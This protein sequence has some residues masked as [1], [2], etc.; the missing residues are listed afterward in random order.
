M[1]EELNEQ[2]RELQQRIVIKATDLLEGNKPKRISWMHYMPNRAWEIT[3]KFEF[4]DIAIN[5]ILGRRLEIRSRSFIVD[6]G[7]LYIEELATVSRS[8]K[9]V[10]ILKITGTSVVESQPGYTDYSSWAE[11]EKWSYNLLTDD[12]DT[13]KGQALLTLLGNIQSGAETGK[14]IF[15]EKLSS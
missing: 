15:D 8:S 4:A 2:N 7:R 10:N 5:G 14:G 13:E 12:I 1:S 9:E 6:Y 3:P 11:K